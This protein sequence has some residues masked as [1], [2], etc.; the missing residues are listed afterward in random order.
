MPDTRRFGSILA[1]PM[2]TALRVIMLRY[3][4]KK[5]LFDRQTNHT[6]H[7]GLTITLHKVVA[8]NYG[9]IAISEA[10]FGTDAH[11]NKQESATAAST[12]T[13]AWVRIIQDKDFEYVWG[14]AE[15]AYKGARGLGIISPG[16]PHDMLDFH[17]D[18]IRFISRS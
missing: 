3:V 16:E 11:T 17:E 2:P 5:R 18:F 10:E 8:G 12:Q 4:W 6:Q 13:P 1:V 7:R 15:L 9:S 14:N